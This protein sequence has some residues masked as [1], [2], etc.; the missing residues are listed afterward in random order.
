MIEA[1]VD[2]DALQCVDAFEKMGVL[3]EDVDVDKVHT[4]V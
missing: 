4:K 3:T 2:S 1:I